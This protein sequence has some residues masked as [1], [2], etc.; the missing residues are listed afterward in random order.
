MKKIT[1]SKLKVGRI[2]KHITREKY[3]QI[4]TIDVKVNSKGLNTI[5]VKYLDEKKTERRCSAFN[6]ARYYCYELE[7]LSEN[8]EIYKKFVDK[9]RYNPKK[10][11]VK[12][13]KVK[14]KEE[15]YE[16]VVKIVATKKQTISTIVVVGLAFLLI[17]MAIIFLGSEAS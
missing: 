1:T 8:E 15:D 17:L 5:M 3:R 14:Q 16:P 10:I 12:E 7:N 11:E 4:L 13:N 9:Y 6:F 2:Y